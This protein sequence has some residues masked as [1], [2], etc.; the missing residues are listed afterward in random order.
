MSF[1]DNFYIESKDLSRKTNKY[2][3]IMLL[4]FIRRFLK[5]LIV[6]LQSEVMISNYW[7]VCVKTIDEMIVPITN[8]TSMCKFCRNWILWQ[9]SIYV[10]FCLGQVFWLLPQYR[11]FFDFYPQKDGIFDFY[12]Y[13]GLLYYDIISTTSWHLESVVLMSRGK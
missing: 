13:T 6:G 12:P 11:L 9:L 10:C 8:A 5:T 4:F 1:T 3:R 7:K 2:W